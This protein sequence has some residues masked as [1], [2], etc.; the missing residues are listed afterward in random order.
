MEFLGSKYTI[1]AVVYMGLFL[2]VN[3]W[4]QSFHSLLLEA[5]ENNPQLKALR[6]Q[7][8]AAKQAVGSAGMLPDPVFSYTYYVEP[9]ETRVGPQE[10]KFSL[11][12]K[13]P[14]FGVRSLQRKTAH[15]TA[16]TQWE[17]YQF[18]RDQLYFEVINTWLQ[19][20]LLGQKQQT[21]SNHIELLR[22]G[23]QTALTRLKG[24]GSVLAVSRI[25]IE[26]GQIE[27]RLESTTGRIKPFR[28]QM[29][30]L[31]N[32]SAETS[33]P[34]PDA[35]PLYA[36]TQSIDE[37]QTQM[38][39]HNPMLKGLDSTIEK[40]IHQI[41]LADREGYPDMQFKLDYIQTGEAL[42]PDTDDSGQDA[43]MATVGVNLPIWRKSYRAT[44]AKARFDAQAVQENRQALELQLLTALA[45][46]FY[47]YEDAQRQL[48]FQQDV[49]MPQASQMLNIATEQFRTG[50]AAFQVMIDAQRLLLDTQL[51]LDRA[52]ADQ[53]RA[54]FSIQQL[55]GTSPIEPIT[56]PTKEPE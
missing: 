36:L 26:L 4:G 55:L 9:V 47:D 25:Q 1:I 30:S 5:E 6:F 34:V 18:H 46:A 10:Q 54:Y 42:M 38:L 20:V 11:T 24:G 37:L 33:T 2:H 27:N 49:M 56:H 8:Q 3:V 28:Q 35:L 44:A 41:A 23:E 29:N 22:D 15:E 21:L 7:W 52:T 14:W 51:M 50:A 13:V 16:L 53:A 40:S 19:L 39:D 48:R 12:Q 32:R 45:N 43:V 31:L 17:V